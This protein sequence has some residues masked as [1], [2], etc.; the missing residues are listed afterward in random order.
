MSTA[1]VTATPLLVGV[2]QAARMLGVSRSQLYLMFGR[3]E[4]DSV[5]VGKRHLVRFADLQTIAE[6]GST[7]PEPELPFALAKALTDWL[8]APGT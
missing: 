1:P 5:H 8:A 6:A 4:L 2:A 7:K 3:G